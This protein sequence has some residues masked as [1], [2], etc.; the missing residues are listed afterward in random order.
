MSVEV[1]R[2]VTPLGSG[3]RIDLILRNA[4]RTPQTAPR[5]TEALPGRA[6]T[7]L[8]HG[9][10]SWSVVRRCPPDDSRP[11]RAETPEAVRG[12]LVGEP[13]AAGRRVVADWVC[14]WEGGVAGW[15]G[16]RTH[17][18]VV[19]VAPDGSLAAAAVLDGV[20]LAP[21]EERTL[22]PLWVATGD[23]GALYSEFCAHAGAHGGARLRGPAPLGWCSWYQWFEGVRPAHVRANLAE[24][25]AH[26]IDVVQIDDGWQAAIGDW[27]DTAPEWGEPIGELA[28][29][30]AGAGC[31]P[32]IWTAPFLLGERSRLY[33][34]HPDWVVVH[35]SGRPLRAA[36]NPGNWGGW[37]YALDTTRPDVRSWLTD[38]FAALRS[39]GFAYHKVDFCYS[40]AME[41]RRHDPGVSRTTALRLGL[42]AVRAGIG[43]DAFLVGCGCPLGPAVGVVD[44][45]RVSADVAPHWEPTRHWPGFAEAAPA[46]ANAVRASVLR[47]PMHG[48]LWLND[49][50]CVLLR[51]H[52]SSLDDA[53]REALVATVEAAGGFTVLSDDLTRYGPDEWAA[54]ERLRRASQ[55]PVDLADPFAPGLVP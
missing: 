43:D 1:H 31:T 3:L 35:R 28:A 18:G 41:G 27:L 50:D 46:A 19:E 24:A 39:L 26:G 55:A 17:L 51:R 42:E 2:R 47:S 8:E 5:V 45:M 52:D 7:V 21:G 16:G 6:G 9:W 4:T 10:Q 49:P 32:G 36:F 38:T 25:A 20:E 30:I 40:A 12:S 14:V 54:V 22:D 13:S 44:A 53:Q 11:E 37:A 48:R 33:R 29:E 15:L 23:P 34:E